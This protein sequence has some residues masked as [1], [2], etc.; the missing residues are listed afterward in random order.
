[1]P[2]ISSFIKKNIL[3]FSLIFLVYAWFFVNHITPQKTSLNVL[4]ADS[5]ISLFQEPQAGR[6]PILNALNSAKSE[7]LIEV[8]L[9]SDKQ[10]IKSLEDAKKRGVVVDVMLEEHPFGGGN[11][12]NNSKTELSKAGIGVEWANSSFSLT[13]EKTIVIDK[14]RAFILNQNLTA[15]SFTK[16]REYDVYDINQEDV[17]EIRNVFISDWERK[18]FTPTKTNLIISPINSRPILTGLIEKAY[19]ELDLEIEDIND[20]QIVSQ[21][22]NKSEKINI[23]IIIPTLSQVSSN[24]DSINKLLSCGV[25]IKTVSSPYIH[26][27]LIL[28]DNI[29]AYIGSVNLSTQSM[30][31]NREVGIILSQADSLKTLLQTF[32][33]DWNIGKSIN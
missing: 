23:K 29:K 26:A 27:K 21:L 22:C 19:K 14:N 6:D 18:N 5:N 8:Y 10:I 25:Y 13:H 3:V 12:N 9:L 2:L 31:K 33:S 24:K 17:A 7:I 4:G 28:V 15:S 30:D 16:N 1:M 32:N 20:E 11:L